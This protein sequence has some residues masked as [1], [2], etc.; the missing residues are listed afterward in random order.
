MVNHV[1]NDVAYKTG[2]ILGHVIPVIVVVGL[3]G[4]ILS[5]LVMMQKHNR[6]S[7]CGIYL[8]ALAVTDSILLCS[9]GHYWLRMQDFFKPLSK[10]E[11]ITIVYTGMVS[12]AI[13][14]I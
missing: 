8:G 10:W 11:C 6:N 9:A 12:N 3:G 13:I 5:L 1:H 7:S 2:V 14:Y 4:N